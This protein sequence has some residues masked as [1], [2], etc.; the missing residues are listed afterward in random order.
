MIL[1]ST[2]FIINDFYRVSSSRGVARNFFGRKLHVGYHGWQTKFCDFRLVKIVTFDTVPAC[3]VIPPSKPKFSNFSCPPDT[4]ILNKVRPRQTTKP[5]NPN[6]LH[7]LNCNIYTDFRTAC[8]HVLIP[9][10]VKFEW[11]NRTKVSQN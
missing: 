9:S 2:G 6:I 10:C 3:G 11:L 8:K 1:T 7:V 4:K 5:D